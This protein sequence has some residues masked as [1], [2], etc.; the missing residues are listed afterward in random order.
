MQKLVY[1]LV[2]VLVIA[3]SVWGALVYTKG[4][5]KRRVDNSIRPVV[6][7]SGGTSERTLSPAASEPSSPEANTPAAA[8]RQF[9]PSLR[10]EDGELVVVDPPSNFND[11]ALSL[12][13]VVLER[14]PLGSLGM[15][16]VRLGVPPGTA[17]PSARRRLL[18]R[19]PGL[20]VDANHQ[21]DESGGTLLAD[22]YHFSIIGTAQAAQDQRRNA[23]SSL[24]RAAIGWQDIPETCGRGV[25]LGMIDSSI[26]LGHP[27]LV[28]RNIEFQSFH[29]PKRRPGPAT[30]GTAVAALLVGNPAGK[31]FGGLLPGAELKAANMFE[32][33]ATGKKVGN[34]IALLKGLN[35]LIGSGVHA[36]N[37]SIA[38][39]DN[40]AVKKAFEIAQR[41]GMI[42]V[43]A[44]GNWGTDDRPAYPAAYGNVLAVT[45]ID[46]YQRI[47]RN[48]NRGSYIEFAAPGVNMWTAVPGGG[49][50]QSGTSFAA[51]YITALLGLEVAHGA[52]RNPDALRNV[53]R[54][55]IAD[56]GNP[57]RDNVFGWGYI[58][59][60]P[61]C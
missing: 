61:N 60:Q 11:V 8:I 30:H 21:F 1:L 48:A 54:E 27:A 13:F 20:L 17:V 43:A 4:E 23:V 53:L 51:P 49:K 55:G 26:D 6:S 5:K 3:A 34:V 33:D 14:V 39:S 35:W 58:R 36:I 25:R 46:P 24:A 10:Y 12:G 16:V 45:A 47:Y 18:G 57:G 15:V 50:Y 9:D 32:R 56:L 52:S 7:A 31:G 29:N 2:V 44:A 38:G 22:L 59:K 41:K 37:L 19:F 28:G 42:M 40:R